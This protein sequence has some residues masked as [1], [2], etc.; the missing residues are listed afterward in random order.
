MQENTP[1]Y[2]TIIVGGRPA[3]ATLAARLG[4]AGLR[5][6]LLERATVPSLPA[7]SSPVIYP[8]TMR[9]LDEIGAD[10]REYAAGTPPIRRLV[11]E[12]REDFRIT[13]RLPALFGRDYLYAIDRA[14]FDAALWRT[15]ARQP[16]VSA[17]AGFSVTELLRDGERVT[18]IVGR[19]GGVVERFTADCVVGA[20]GRFST[21]ARQAGAAIRDEHTDMPTTIYYAYWRNVAPYDDGEPAVHSYGMGRGYGFGIFNSAD[22]TTCVVIEGRADRLELGEEKAS[23]LYM[24]MLRAHPRVWRRL[25]GADMAT[26]VRGMRKIGNC[27][28]EAGGAGWALVGDALHQKDPLDGQGIYDAVATAKLL[29]TALIDWKQGRLGWEAAL[30]QYDA[31]VRAETMPMYQETM[32]R[33]KRELYTEQPDWA[34]HTW[35]RWLATDP[36]YGRRLIMLLSR[37]IPATGWLPASV[38]FKALLRGAVR[39]LA[40]RLAHMPEPHALPPLAS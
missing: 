23:E 18:G 21:V 36:E 3:G 17:R 28:R 19:A 1:H 39:D 34:Y 2:D 24:R 30:S 25:A 38:F 27:Y 14:R 7:A 31:A 29:A 8:A 6:L 22:G 40:R 35:L 9:L 13:L 26:E 16:G 4:Q 10:E 11:S 20:D 12:V 33:V 5:V 32:Q 37:G 15:A